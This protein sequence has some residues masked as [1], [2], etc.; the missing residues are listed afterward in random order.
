MSL[1]SLLLSSDEK[2]VKVLR[3]VLSDLEI[4]VDYCST[5]EAALRKLTRQRF[6]AVIVD[7]SNLDEARAVLKSAQSSPANN[8]AVAIILV[9][10]SVGLRGGFE[11]GGHFVLHK[12]LS[13]ERARSSFRAVR[14]LMKRERR[15][16]ARVAVQLPVECRGLKSGDHYKAHTIDLCEGG[17]AVQFQ[18]HFVKEGSL[19]FSL[20]LPGTKI[21]LELEGEVAWEGHPGQAGVRFKN[22]PDERLFLLRRWLG[23]QLPELEQDDPPLNCRLSDLSLG[24]CYLETNSPFCVRTRVILSLKTGE[25]K[26]WARGVVRIM[27]PEFGMGIEFSQSTPAQHEQVHAMIEM[28]RAGGES[29]AE[30]KVEPDGLETMAEDSAAGEWPEAEDSLVELFRQ[31]TDVPIEAFL[32]QMRQQ[33]R[34]VELK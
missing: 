9:E 25:F 3:R 15:R 19:R 31:K 8:R 7:C 16:Q 29:A 18:G 33:R 12:P 2:T 26:A 11:M 30:L 20:D 6:E 22:V 28:L 21:K 23:S 1:R 27:H 13:G 32:Q 17:M 24:G 10:A 14:A 5:S 4:S 34:V